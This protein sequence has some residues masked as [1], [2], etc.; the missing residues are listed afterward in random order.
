MANVLHRTS[1]VF[2]SS[3]NTPDFSPVTWIINPDMSEV[4]GFQ[5]KYWII[6]GDIV[7]LMT[8]IERDAVDAAEAAAL[9]LS[10][11]SIGVA[12]IDV[13]PNVN[14]RA[15]IHS[16]NQRINFATNRIIELQ[17]RVQAMLDSTGGVANL[18]TDGLA[19][20]ISATSTRPL[21]D[22]IQAYKDDINSGDVDG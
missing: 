14:E 21:P 18:R 19:V 9:V 5:D 7:T 1:K 8:Q 13:P 17:D 16:L 15:I 20:S 10:H 6:T 4:E 11:R 22:A 3:Q 12:S 2:L